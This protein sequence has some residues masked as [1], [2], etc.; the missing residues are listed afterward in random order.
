MI[1]YMGSTSDGGFHGQQRAQLLWWAMALK[2]TLDN[3]NVQWII[4]K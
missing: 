2:F 1:A 3:D 4:M